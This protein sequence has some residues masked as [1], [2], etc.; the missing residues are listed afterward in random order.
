MKTA[1]SY[2]PLVKPTIDTASHPRA[3]RRSISSCPVVAERNTN[4]S[5]FLKGAA[6]AFATKDTTSVRVEFRRENV[7]V[8]AMFYWQWNTCEFGLLTSLL[9]I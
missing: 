5:D 1:D 4:C 7:R 8:K 6:L 3:L 2:V 9:P